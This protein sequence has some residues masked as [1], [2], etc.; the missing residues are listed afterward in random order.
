VVSRKA[1][2]QIE[3]KSG[4]EVSSEGL[5]WFFGSGYPAF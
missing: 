2:A 3:S 5:F 1:N 4:W